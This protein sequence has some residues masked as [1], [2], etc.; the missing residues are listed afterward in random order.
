[1]SPHDVRSSFRVRFALAAFALVAMLAP[2]A[3]AA[4]T[5]ELVLRG[6]D[7]VELCAGREV[8][9]VESLTET[10]SGFVYRFANETNR[11]RFRE[12]PDELAVQFAGACGKMGPLS[13]RGAPDR[14]H[15]HEGRIY[16]FASD[17]CR[18]SFLRE[19]AKFI[20]RADPPPEGDAE[21]LKRGAE[22]MALAVRGLGGEEPLA[23]TN[24]VH[25]RTVTTR[26]GDE[27]GLRITTDR[28]IVFPGTYRLDTNWGSGGYAWLL[29]PRGG[30]LPAETSPAVEDSVRAYMARELYRNPVA[31]VMAWRRGDVRAVALA[32]VERAGRKCVRVAASVQ[33]A[34]TEL[35]LDA[36]N[37]RCIETEYRGR[38]G[39]GIGRLVRRFSEFRPVGR[40]CLPF[41]VEIEIDG[42]TAPDKNE[43]TV[44]EANVEIPDARIAEPR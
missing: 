8:A 27:T 30:Y 44:V 4:E 18:A 42:V 14:F 38:G 2:R 24:N 20:D 31:I 43:I 10:R 9:G 7:P 35:T 37:G 40:L 16:L 39:I 36:E 11:A 29:T 17:G 1:M 21:A 34:T 23:Q 13:G 19:P 41:A 12:R 26:A 6:L 5:P 22:L 3:S 28:W 33:G 25:V 15:V 32:P